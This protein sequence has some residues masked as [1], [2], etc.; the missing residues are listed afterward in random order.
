[1]LGVRITRPIAP[2]ALA[3]RGKRASGGGGAILLYHR[4]ADHSPDV[5]GLCVTPEAFAAQMRLLREEFH[6]VSLEALVEAARSGAIPERSVAVSFD[7]GYLDSLRV[8]S[9]V[10][11]QEGIPATFFVNTDR[12]EV[13]HETWNDTLER[14]FLAEGPVLA[15]L[16]IVLE[17]ERLVLPTGTARER[18]ETFWAL[19]RRGFGATASGRAALVAA[20]E[21]WRQEAQPCRDSH[22]LMTGEEIVQLSR[23]PGHTVGAH[24]THHLL[25]PAHPHPIQEQ[26]ISENRVWLEAKLAVPVGGFAYP[27][28]AM[29]SGVVELVRRLG[30]SYAVTV[31]EGL[32]LPG[33]DPFLLRR[34][35]I[36]PEQAFQAKLERAFTVSAGDT[37]S[38]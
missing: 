7:D 24:T 15:E 36:K 1:M 3:H 19:F 18:R 5:H 14:I 13:P 32:V 23:R 12:V 4:I 38:R 28:G 10:L 34:L 17:G 22:R 21:Q 27:Y 25:L 2:G 30:F 35:E 20:V 26:E 31:E 33:A 8:A 37:T 6:P 9:P 16:S 11:Q 29:D